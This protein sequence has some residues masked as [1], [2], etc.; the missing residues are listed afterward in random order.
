MFNFSPI[1]SMNA[2]AMYKNE[3]V[4]IAMY[5][6]LISKIHFTLAILANTS[7][8][9]ASAITCQ[10]L[11][12]LGRSGPTSFFGIFKLRIFEAILMEKGGLYEENKPENVFCW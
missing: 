6:V 3:K 2:I 5:E 4:E 8:R 9:L 7:C 12:N 11:T 10:A 1:N